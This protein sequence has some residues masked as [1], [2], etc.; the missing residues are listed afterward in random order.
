MSST[1]QT[2]QTAAYQLAVASGRNQI[3]LLRPWLP[4]HMAAS[5]GCCVVEQREYHPLGTVIESDISIYG[6]P[7]A[8]AMCDINIVDGLKRHDIAK[9]RPGANSAEWWFFDDGCAPWHGKKHKE[10]Y[11]QLLID[12]FG[13]ELDAYKVEKLRFR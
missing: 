11:L 13:I 7:T 3:R 12:V 2:I 8:M 5:G 9:Y 10:R 6:E 4:Y 1:K